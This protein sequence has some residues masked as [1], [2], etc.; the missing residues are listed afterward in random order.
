M[1]DVMY[2]DWSQ[3]ERELRLSAPIVRFRQEWDAHQKVDRLEDELRNAR[4]A[5]QAEAV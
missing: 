4:L 1:F 2:N 3:A 5:R